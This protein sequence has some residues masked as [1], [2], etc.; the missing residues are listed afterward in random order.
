MEME[1]AIKMYPYPPC[2]WNFMLTPTQIRSLKRISG[3]N[4]YLAFQL[5]VH[6]VKSQLFKIPVAASAAPCPH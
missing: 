4:I 5:L 3:C 1:E 2:G 6:F